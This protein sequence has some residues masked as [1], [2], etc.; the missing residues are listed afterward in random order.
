MRIH[1]D[2]ADSYAPF[3]TVTVNCPADWTSRPE[4]KRYV[5]CLIEVDVDATPLSACAKSENLRRWDAVC[6]SCD[7]VKK[8]QESEGLGQPA[9]RSETLTSSHTDGSDQVQDRSS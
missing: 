8:T 7:A 6:V 3:L 2:G 4:P 5:V 1:V 9:L